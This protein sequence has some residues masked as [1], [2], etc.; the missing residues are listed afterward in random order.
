MP[1]FLMMKEIDQSHL[2]LK[3]AKREHRNQLLKCVDSIIESLESEKMDCPEQGNLVPFQAIKNLFRKELSSMELCN[4]NYFKSLREFSKDI[5]KHFISPEDLDAIYLEC[6]WETPQSSAKSHLINDQQKA[7]KE[8]KK[9][10][11][12]TTDSSTTTRRRRPLDLAIDEFQISILGRDNNDDDDETRNPFFI[13]RLV[14]G[15]IRQMLRDG[16]LNIANDHFML[17]VTMEQQDAETQTE[18]DEMSKAH[19]MEDDD[20]EEEGTMNDLISTGI[21][22]YLQRQRYTNVAEHYHPQ[23]TLPSHSIPNLQKIQEISQA[24]LNHSTT[25][26]LAWCKEHQEDASIAYLQFKTHEILFAMMILKKQPYSE[27]IS[28]ARNNLDQFRDVFKEETMRVIGLLMHRQLDSDAFEEYQD[29]APWL[30]LRDLFINSAS[31]VYHVALK[32]PLYMLSLSSSIA[33][34]KLLHQ[35]RVLGDREELRKQLQV[36]MELGEHFQFRSQLR[37]PLSR[38]LS[39]SEN[40]AMVLQCG[41]VLTK[42]AVEKLSKRKELSLSRR[43]RFR[44]I[45]FKCPYCPERS[46]SDKCI[47]LHYA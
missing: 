4:R 38:Q 24:I 29:E 44:Q 3:E 31:V 11:E 21:H 10:E 26:L 6:V 23:R 28:Y 35:Q 46:T 13:N 17:Q 16:N 15:Q 40:P 22:D 12:R 32:D 34:P 18:D 2:R 25:L 7:N 8:E 43:S 19:R 47:R 42:K 33:I 39:T 30:R 27:I 45:Q 37:C 41:H 14:L 9:N 20:V 5:N 1:D 36:D